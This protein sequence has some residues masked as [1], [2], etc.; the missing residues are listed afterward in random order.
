MTHSLVY[1]CP[2]QFDEFS[3]VAKTIVRATERSIFGQINLLS[4][5][6]TSFS[7]ANGAFPNVTIVNFDHRVAEAGLL[8]GS[9]LMYYVPI[10]KESQRSGWEQYAVDHQGWVYSDWLTHKNDTGFASNPGNIS[11]HIFGFQEALDILAYDPHWKETVKRA[12]WD[13]ISQDLSLSY[14]L[15][16]PSPVVGEPFNLPVWQTG[17]VPKNATI[18]NFDIY[19]KPA[20]KPVVDQALEVSHMLLSR[21]WALP[22]LTYWMDHGDVIY[23]EPE[24]F[25]KSPH[26]I[27]YARFHAPLTLLLFFIAVLQPIY[28]NFFPG[29]K[30]VAFMIGR[31]E[32]HSFFDNLLPPG[33]NGILADVEGDCGDHFTYRIDGPTAQYLG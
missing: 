17:P 30:T 7:L 25:C 9:G 32:W 8:S 31:I 1:L 3:N 12:H 13:T 28:E 11:Q 6:L 19:T 22:I 5:T 24:S 15:G 10:V 16:P 14:N 26:S 23:T 33:I 20:F 27:C 21:I 29:S 18:V 4:V 2:Q